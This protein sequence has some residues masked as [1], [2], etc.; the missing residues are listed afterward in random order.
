MNHGV[1]LSTVRTQVSSIRA[2]TGTENISSLVRMVAMLPPMVSALRQVSTASLASRP[3][4]VVVPRNGSLPWMQIR[5]MA[6]L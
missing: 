3:R 4:P 1:A 6:T 2:K 5:E